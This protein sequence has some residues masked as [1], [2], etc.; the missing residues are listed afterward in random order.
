MIVWTSENIATKTTNE[1]KSLRANA[2]KRRAKEI[3]DLCDTELE[4]RKPARVPRPKTVDEFRAG[5]VVT[6]FHFVCP[7]EKGVTRNSDK[8]AWTGTWVVAEAHAKRGVKHGMKVALHTAKS[9]PSYM[10]GIIKDW[11]KTKR[12]DEYAEDRP[13]KI[14]YG[15]DFLF[16][17]TDEALPWVGDGSGEKGYAWG[18]DPDRQQDRT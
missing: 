15:V 12:E 3:V 1:V 9:E 4:K 18:P 6:E 16:A 10:Q 17:S 2:I 13:V 7:G 5:Q 8:T 14:E 11:R